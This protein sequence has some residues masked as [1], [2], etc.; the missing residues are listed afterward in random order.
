[1][2]SALRGPTGGL[3]LLRRNRHASPLGQTPEGER[4]LPRSII[5]RVE[6]YLGA[7]VTPKQVRRIRSMAYE[8][9]RGRR[10]D[11]TGG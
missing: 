9:R 4:I 2:G 6:H 11:P 3:S 10:L 7:K 5:G 8:I 1:M